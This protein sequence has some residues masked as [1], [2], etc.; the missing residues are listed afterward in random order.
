MHADSQ[1]NA[2]RTQTPIRNCVS[3]HWRFLVCSFMVLGRREHLLTPQASSKGLEYQE[4]Q[5]IGLREAS[6]ARS[7]ELVTV[8]ET[9][10]GSLWISACASSTCRG[11]D[12]AQPS[13]LTTTCP[14]WIWGHCPEH[15]FSG[16]KA[17]TKASSFPGELGDH[18]NT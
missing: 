11:T 8:L 6:P 18:V 9:R 16:C 15:Q 5:R 14:S 17:E 3:H 10:K 4:G 12:E 7:L 13:S 2:S 1:R